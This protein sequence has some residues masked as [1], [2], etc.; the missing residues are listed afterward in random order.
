MPDMDRYLAPT[1]NIDW[2]DSSISNTARL[3]TEGKPD[4][5]ERARSLFY[6]VRDRIKYNPYRYTLAPEYLRA[7]RTL[8]RG[9][10][11]CIQKAVLLAA[12]A[13]ATG[14]SARLLFADIRNYMISRKQLEIQGG[15]NLFTDHGYC[16]L[17]IEEKWVKATPAFDLQTCVEHH[18]VPVEFDGESD[19]ILHRY[20]QEGKL[21]IEYVKI[22]GHYDDV[23]LEEIIQRS[24]QAYGH[25]RTEAWKNG[26][27][28]D[29]LQC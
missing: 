27:W 6:F 26:F 7:S 3:L 1:A 16:E 5:K 24:V 15:T 9:D 23:P 18:I 11:F 19:A 4:A 10:G 21:H 20:D 29:A 17:Y 22:H 8:Q 25:K 13:R 28:A 14:M 2:D 12:L